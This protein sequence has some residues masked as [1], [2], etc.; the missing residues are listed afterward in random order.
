MKKT[1]SG[2][3]LAEILILIVIVIIAI[4][5]T[6]TVV[7]YNGIQDRARTTNI[8][9]LLTAYITALEMYKI[10]NGYYPV[11]S[12]VDEMQNGGWRS[13]CLGL[14]SNYQATRSLQMRFAQI[15]RPKPAWR[16]YGANIIGVANDV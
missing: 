13:M 4:L 8:S 11:L 7:I 2:F 1:T 9:T 3:T 12:D 14:D 16:L 6:I 5:T 15:F 10:D